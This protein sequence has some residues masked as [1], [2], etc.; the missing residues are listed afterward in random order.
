MASLV[1]LAIS[2]ILINSVILYFRPEEA[3]GVFNQVFAVY[4]VLSQFAICGFQLSTLKQSAQN[5]DDVAKCGAIL[6]AALILTTSLSLVFA[7]C[8][9]SLSDLI[10][11]ILE[12]TDV[13]FGLKL[14]APGLIFFCLNK[15]ILMSLNGRQQMRA[16]AIFQ[17]LRFVFILIG[18]CTILYS[19]LEHG[20]LA[21]ALSAAESIL[22]IILLIFSFPV[23]RARTKSS[24]AL[25]Y[26]C[27]THITFGTKG[28]LGGI[29]I[30]MNTRV[31][32]LMLGIFLSD[33]H[34]GIYSFAAI[35]AEGFAQL[36][37]VVR[38]NF[39][40]IAGK[41]I[42]DGKEDN[43]LELIHTLRK[44]FWIAMLV[45]GLVSLLIFPLIYTT[46]NGGALI[47]NAFWVYLILTCGY[48]IAS[49]QTPFSGIMLHKNRPELFSL[50]QGGTVLSNIT[51]NFFLI[52]I[53][54]II[55]G[56]IATSLAII[57]QAV[58]IGFIITKLLSHP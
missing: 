19:G 2:G 7:L 42:A 38:Q 36:S 52:P 45:L 51:F 56:A 48:V 35:F 23:L 18:I 4:I 50:V 26:W 6:F 31:D 40:P 13:A 5:Q 27:K 10:G 43:L 41:D 53:L 44:R 24:T 17:S 28:L 55:G 49:R 15:V 29:L 32:V 33:A 9:Y 8:L 12:S 57:L 21:L 58:F 30:E 11:N 14:V 16:F 46:I 3:L 47:S 39:D 22:F 20:Y 25:K 37:T 54:G 34:V 1:V